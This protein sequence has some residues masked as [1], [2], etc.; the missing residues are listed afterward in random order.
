MKKI[1]NI[2]PTSV[3]FIHFLKN[4]SILKS[5]HFREMSLHNGKQTIVF[6][7]TNLNERY[8]KNIILY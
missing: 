7:K 4:H 6:G 5:F 1:S 2:S 8:S 3:T